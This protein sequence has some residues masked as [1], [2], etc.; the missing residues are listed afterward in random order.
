PVAA[1]PVLMVGAAFHQAIDVGIGVLAEHPYEV[2][3]RDDVEDVLDDAVGDE[4]LAALVPVEAPGVRR[5]VGIDFPVVPH[6]MIAP[7][8]AVHDLPPLGRRARLADER[9]GGDAVAAVEPAVGPPGQISDDVVLAFERET[10][11]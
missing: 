10:V 6:R 7:Y 3:A 4:Q 2:S 1:G 9:G 8:A 5:A 11:E